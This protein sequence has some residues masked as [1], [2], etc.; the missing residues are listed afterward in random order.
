ML[1]RN[2]IL[3]T[4]AM[5]GLLAAGGMRALGDHV[6]VDVIIIGA[7]PAGI[8]AARRIAASG[9]S[10]ALL[11]A[12]ARPGGRVVTDTAL[13]GV[14]FDLGAHWIHMPRLHPLS[15]L[16]RKAGF[17]IYRGPADM[18]LFIGHA[19]GSDA[20]YRAFEAA[21]GRTEKA[22]VRAGEAGR[23]VPAS[24]AAPKP[25]PWNATAAL[26]LGPLSCGKELGAV[27]TLD[28]ARSEEEGVDEFCREGFG[29]LIAALA[30]PLA[31]H[32]LTPAT[33]IDLRQRHPAVETPRGVLKGRAVICT[34]PPSLMADGRVRVRPGLPA[35]YE[36]AMAHLSLGAY[37][38]IAFQLSGNPLD[39][40]RDEFA[41]FRTDDSRHGCAILGRIGGTDLHSVE[42]GG[43][44]ARELAAREGAAEAFARAVVAEHCG[45][46]AAER[47]G[48][49]HATRWTEEPW[50]GGAFSCAE[51]GSAHLRGVLTHPVADALIFAGE[52]THESLWGTVGGAWLS[53]E[54]AARQAL[55]LVSSRQVHA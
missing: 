3:G 39:L 35:R 17:D 49:V 32:F 9:H 2:L 33:A 18:R 5:A 15:K 38:H 20:D 6:E 45:S 19:E 28:Y 12:S 8:A 21:L 30:A 46:E 7:G 13:F 16:G 1:R 25:S 29:T 4:T 44:L 26:L 10:Y 37:D 50:A 27:S 43:S 11:E 36:A 31:I 48:P 14:P 34:V 54:R 47:M 41:C 51:P 55:R 40:G 52:H 42:V 53:G 23:D 22:I 24:Q